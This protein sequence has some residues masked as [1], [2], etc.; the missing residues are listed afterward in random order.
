[1]R[2]IPAYHIWPSGDNALT[3]DFGNIIDPG[4]NRWVMMINNAL[5]QHPCPGFTETVPA[6]ASLTVYYNLL[7]LVQLQKGN[8]TVF[9]KIKNHVQKII[10][11]LSINTVNELPATIIE[12][13]VCYHPSQGTD[14]AALAKAKDLPIQKIIDLHAAR[15]Y[16]VYMTGFLPGFA[17][18]GQVDDAIAH[19]RK[20]TP[21]PVK[22]GSVGIAGRQTGIYPLHSPGGWHIIGRTP[23]AMFDAS[24][25]DSCYLKPGNIVQFKPIALDEFNSYPH[26]PA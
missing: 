14:I 8:I 18:M 17:Y 9:D 1:M 5:A 11:S 21:V 20:K 4:I 22:A 13:P 2:Q 25:D 24:A 7:Q 12:I 10:D 26:R 23:I 3:I 6:Y 16:Q 19:P 15:E